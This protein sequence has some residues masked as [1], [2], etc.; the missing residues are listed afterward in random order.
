[1]YLI[2]KAIHQNAKNIT[3]Y[4]NIRKNGRFLKESAAVDVE[5][6]IFIN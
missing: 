1:V 2:D 4:H 6:R 5:L 3:H